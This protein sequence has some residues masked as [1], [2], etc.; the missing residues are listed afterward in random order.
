MDDT[1]LVITDPVVEVATVAVETATKVNPYQ[2]HNTHQDID[3]WVSAFGDC[4]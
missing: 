1:N 4:V 3:A 2:S